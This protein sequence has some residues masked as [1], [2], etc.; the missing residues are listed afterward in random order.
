MGSKKPTASGHRCDS[1]PLGKIVACGGEQDWEGVNG[2][3][4]KEWV[5][6][7]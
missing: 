3:V 2:R 1:L 6:E 4:I 7:E 5:M